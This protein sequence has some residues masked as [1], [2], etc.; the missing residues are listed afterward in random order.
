MNKRESKG[1]VGQ[2]M[3]EDA[4]CLWVVNVKGCQ[5]ELEGW[6]VNG[7]IVIVQYFDVGGCTHYVQSKTLTWD[8][9][10]AELESLA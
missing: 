10:K 5:F 9:M 8:N 6:L 3:P 7:T 1:R 2:L 4:R